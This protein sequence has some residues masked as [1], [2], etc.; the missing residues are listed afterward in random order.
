MRTAQEQADADYRRALEK[1][2][3]DARAYADEFAGKTDSVVK[4][5]VRRISLGR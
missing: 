3:E 1:S 2:A 4:E 5:I